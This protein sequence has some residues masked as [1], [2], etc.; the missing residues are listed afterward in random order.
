ME[1]RNAM[2]P[3]INLEEHAKPINAFGGKVMRVV[4]AWL[5]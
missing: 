2:F 4:K 3:I 5:S 1:Q